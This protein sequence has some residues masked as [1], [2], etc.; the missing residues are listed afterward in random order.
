MSTLP[1]TP[2]LTVAQL[3]ER[4][5]KA[6]IHSEEA[7]LKHT[8]TYRQLKRM[9]N[10]INTNPLDISQYHK[11]AVRM[12]ALLKE[13]IR[14]NT[15]TVFDYYYCNIDPQQMGDVRF[16]RCQCLDLAEQIIELDRWR[17]KRHH[18]TLVK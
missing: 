6:L 1:D 13:L 15:Q 4:R 7:L 3:K 18:L 11:T 12:S 5:E 8:E 14:V 10:E 17:A 2:H 16:F 9:V